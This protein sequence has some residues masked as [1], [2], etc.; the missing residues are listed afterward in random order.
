MSPHSDH[1]KPGNPFKNLNR[2][3]VSNITGKTV[4]IFRSREGE[5]TLCGKGSALRE[6]KLIA[7]SSAIRVSILAF[8]EL[9]TY[10]VTGHKTIETF[11]DH[12]TS[13]K[14]SSFSMVQ[15]HV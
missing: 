9:S 11:K 4:P 8:Y 5:G 14:R 1:L 6:V 13:R 2:G 10:S 15:V 12:F 7:L 3:R